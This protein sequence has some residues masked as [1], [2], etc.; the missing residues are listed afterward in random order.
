MGSFFSSNSKPQPQTAAFDSLNYQAYLNEMFM[1]NRKVLDELQKQNES[2]LTINRQLRDELSDYRK[3][4]KRSLEDKLRTQNKSKKVENLATKISTEAIK[5][6]VELLIENESVN[7]PYLPDFVERQ[8]Y[9]NMFNMIL[10]VL[11]HVLNN[12][13]VSLFNHQIRFDITPLPQ[14]IDDLLQFN[15]NSVPLNENEEDDSETF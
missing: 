15:E 1:E 11:D 10:N 5:Q 12:S 7:V 2:L 4:R 14:Q 6:Y 3:A 8:L 13:H 9:H